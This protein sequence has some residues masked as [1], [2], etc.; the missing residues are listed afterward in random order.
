ML[1][2]NVKCLGRKILGFIIV[3]NQQYESGSK[4]LRLKNVENC[5]GKC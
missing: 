5:R 3:K 1:S 4:L 2:E